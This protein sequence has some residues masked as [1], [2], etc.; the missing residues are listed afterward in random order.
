MALHRIWLVLRREYVF[1]FR[2]PAF[3]FTAFM[4]PVISVGLMFLIIQLTAERESSL[5][6]YD[7]VGYVD[8]AGI[9]EH[10]DWVP[11]RYHAVTDDSLTPPAADADADALT[12]YYNGL[13]D[14]A[15]QQLVDGALDGYFVIADN[16][17]IT[18]RV[19][20]YTE[21]NVP[22]ALQGDI[23]NMLHDQISIG[24]PSSLTLPASPTIRDLDTGE[25]MSETAIV[26]RLMLPFVFAFL[27]FMATNTTAQFLVSG[28]VEEKENRLME[29]LAT[30]IRPLELLWGKLLGLGALALTQIALWSSAGLAIAMLNDDAREF[31][32]G[33]SFRVSDIALILVLFMLNFFLFGAAMLGIGASVTAEAESRQAAGVFSFLTV[34]PMALMVVFL[35]NPNGPLPLFFT[36]F[37]LTSAIGLTLRMGMTSLP[38]WQIAATIGILAVS[39]VGVMWLAAKVF[40]L[41]MLMYGKPLTP[42]TLITALRL[43]QKTLTTAPDSGTPAA[44]PQKKRSLL[45]R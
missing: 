23:E 16:Y 5:D 26:G 33:A 27:Y 24:K 3:L 11:E 45:R 44:P 35:N 32:N 7:R 13:E 29:I 34:L 1:N 43:G 25:E 39:V 38:A 10:P 18:G 19:D 21:D 22:A 40:R 6:D 17:V 36:F 12:S 30:S 2:R 37:P 28:V 42:R 41:G 4:L 8:R 14:A 31:I 20:L 15:R 9:V